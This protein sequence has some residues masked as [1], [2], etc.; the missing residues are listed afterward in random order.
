M[1]T[2]NLKRKIQKYAGNSNNSGSSSTTSEIIVNTQN[3]FLGGYKDE[4]VIPIGT[5]HNQIIEKILRYGETMTF[6]LPTLTFNTNFSPNSSYEVGQTLSLVLSHFFNQ[7]DS[8]GID[9]ITYKKDNSVITN[10]LDLVISEV[11]QNFLV[12]ISYLEGTETKI[13]SIGQVFPNTITNGVL[14]SSVSSFKGIYPTFFGKSS[15]IP[16]ANQT[17]INS[18]TKSIN[19]DL[20]NSS[21]GSFSFNP[22]AVGQYIYFAIPVSSG[23]KSTYYKTSLDT[24]ALSNIFHSP[25]TITIDSPDSLWSSQ[26]YLFYISKAIG[27]HNTN[28][29]IS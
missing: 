17:F 25:V 13:N 5:N 9:S 7:N 21:N 4:E 14:N 20:L 2:L 29:Q 6:D 8:G 3:E 1:K 15:S 24:G 27:T 22:N 26:D 23:L 16:V 28:I 11:F 12:S 19:G 10:S 18:A